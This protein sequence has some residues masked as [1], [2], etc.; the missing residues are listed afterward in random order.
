M[1]FATLHDFTWLQ[2]D[3]AQ[4]GRRPS[5][6]ARHGD[7]SL[8]FS[9][10]IIF[11]CQALYLPIASEEGAE[12]PEPFGMHKL[13]RHLCAFFLISLQVQERRVRDVSRQHTDHEDAA[14]SRKRLHCTFN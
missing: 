1:Q 9:M 11:N 8:Q 12:A 13:R 2:L 4:V 5:G 10:M 7:K 3:I 6:T 14:T